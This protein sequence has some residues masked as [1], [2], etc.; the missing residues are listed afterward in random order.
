MIKLAANENVI[1]TAIGKTVCHTVELILAENRRVLRQ[2]DA[3][4]FDRFVNLLTDGNRIFV[5]GEGRS[6][7]A[8]RM[9]A[10]RLMHLGYRVYVVGET[11]T[12][13][14]GR[15]DLLIAC[16]GS[17]TTS[18]VLTMTTTARLAGGRIVAITTAPESSLG[19]IADL[20][21]T[22]PAAAKQDR[23]RQCSEQF[24]GSLF[25]QAALLLFDAITHALMHRLDK[26]TETLWS[27]HANLE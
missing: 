3:A 17:G 20:V 1:C 23:S 9:F 13:A 26:N 11:T 6:G 14:L 2:V 5:I 15:D 12:P 24:A 25:E 10:M 4:V 8:A 19:K 18:S 21:I 7:L 27:M 16:S 22:I